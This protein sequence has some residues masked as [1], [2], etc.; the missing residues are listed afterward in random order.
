MWQLVHGR[1]SKHQMWAHGCRLGVNGGKGVLQ[2]STASERW[3]LMRARQIGEESF[4]FE[5]IQASL[6]RWGLPTGDVET[7]LEHVKTS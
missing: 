1:A 2:V 4:V 6:D 5:P 7:I 3:E